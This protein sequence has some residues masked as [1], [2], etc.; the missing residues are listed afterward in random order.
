MLA[1][2]RRSL[3]P[4]Q[5]DPQT[6]K[7]GGRWQD[8]SGKFNAMINQAGSHIECWVT[9]ASTLLGI[10]R[11]V[12]RLGGDRT[13]DRDF[14]LY[15]YPD[16]TQA[17]GKVRLLAV[18]KLQM[19]LTSQGVTQTSTLVPIDATR[20]GRPTLSD[21]ALALLPSE[22]A[23]FKVEEQF[24]LTRQER[25][26]LKDKLGVPALAPLINNWLNV[27]SGTNVADR[28]ERE[29]AAGELDAYIGKVFAV[30]HPESIPLVRERARNVVA[31]ETLTFEK[32][33]RTVL[34]W[35]SRIVNQNDQEGFNVSKTPNMK[36]FLGLGVSK[37]TQPFLYQVEYFVEGFSGDF[38][39]GLGG[40]VGFI[41]VTKR[42]GPNPTNKILFKQQYEMWFGGISGGLSA[43][44]QIGMLSSG[45]G[46][47]F[48][49]Y[50]PADIPGWVTFIDGSAKAGAGIGPAG[51]IGGMEIHGN[52][53]QPT[54][55]IDTSGVTAV[56]G[57]VQGFAGLY[58]GAE[59]GFSAGRILKIGNKF[60]KRTFETR[61]PSTDYA[62]DAKANAQ[63]HF[64]LGDA[65]LTPQG[66]QL[67]RIFCAAELATLT[68]AGSSLDL[69]GHADR[70]D[71]AQRNNELSLLRAK[72]VVQ[73]VKDVLGSALSITDDRIATRGLGE[74]RA[75]EAHDL[76][77]S[78][79]P[80][81]RKVEIV[82]DG[83]LS[84]TFVGG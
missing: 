15:V 58:A 35:L 50:A 48:V 11:R 23:I 37:R 73:A 49:D 36:D 20:P 29:K 81:F 32:T 6:P 83:R 10:A 66:R 41:V 84:V 26:L 5:P 43:G 44:F 7:I 9:P 62:V 54:L 56:G 67:L 51:G 75:A 63:V 46:T 27:G 78:V 55:F 64:A 28:I 39:I 14:S 69:E 16:P 40:F 17:S 42:D 19:T 47:S 70:I 21:A 4:A 65:F 79:N 61:I 38:G 2:A 30:F 53:A 34:D 77:G 25:Q 13:S 59:L 22:A 31:V 3:A 68:V 45:S 80:N 82:L 33:Q 57:N 1:R 18:D 12:F 71:T 74:R 8:E 72:N 52:G 24:P 60:P 76:D